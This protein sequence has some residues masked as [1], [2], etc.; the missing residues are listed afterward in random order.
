MS[1]ISRIE[2]NAPKIGLNY[3]RSVGWIN[4]IFMRAIEGEN[5]P[6]E[7]FQLEFR[8]RSFDVQRSQRRRF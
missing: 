8:V 7:I 3:Q 5:I 1:E 2:F 6:A 4:R